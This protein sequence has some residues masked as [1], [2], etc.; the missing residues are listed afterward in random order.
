LHWIIVYLRHKPE[1]YVVEVNIYDGSGKL[2]ESRSYSGVKQVV[3]KTSEVR[4]SRQLAPEPL[5]L[6]TSA[7]KPR[8]ELREGSILYIVDEERSG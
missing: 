4:V 7:A 1:E 2:S 3:F 5:A 6:V 8:V